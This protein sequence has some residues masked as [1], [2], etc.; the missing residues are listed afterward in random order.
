MRAWHEGGDGH[1]YVYQYIGPIHYLC[2]CGDSFLNRDR[3][4][5]HKAV[6]AFIAKQDLR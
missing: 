5:A 6:A 4:I 3:W 2:E 1:G